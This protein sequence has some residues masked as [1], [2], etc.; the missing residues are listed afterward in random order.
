MGVGGSNFYN[1]AF[2]RLGYGDEVA[3][4]AALWQAGHRDEARS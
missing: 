2:S 1:A 3:E 4:V